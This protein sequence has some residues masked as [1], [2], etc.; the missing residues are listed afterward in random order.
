MAA[1]PIAD[2][3]WRWTKSQSRPHKPL[4]L[5]LT[6]SQSIPKANLTLS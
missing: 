5:Q 3:T 4:E 1:T 2:D 6:T